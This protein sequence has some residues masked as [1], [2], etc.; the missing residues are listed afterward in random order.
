MN[1]ELVQAVYVGNM[2]LVKLLLTKRVMINDE[3]IRKA[4]IYGRFEILKLLLDSVKS[5][6]YEE[7][8]RTAKYNRD[9]SIVN[10]LE[11]RM[12]IQK[13]EEL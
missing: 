7:L 4:C 2:E 5:Y 11:K 8:L 1:N 3:A 12:M 6:N 13:L 10:Y 9:L